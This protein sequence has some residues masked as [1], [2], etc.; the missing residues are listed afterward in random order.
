MSHRVLSARPAAWLVLLLLAAPVRSAPA[1]L[2]LQPGSVVA[3][4]GGADVAGLLESGHLETLLTL[5][6]AGDP[7]RFRNFGWEGDTVFQQPRDYGFAPLTDHLRRAAVTAAFLQFGRSEA[8]GDRLDLEEF[9]RAYR[10]LLD[11]FQALGMKIALVTP[12]PFEDGPAP[13]PP[14]SS[15][16]AQLARIAT[17]IRALAE[18]R[19]LACVDLFARLREREAGV[20]LTNDGLQLTASGHALIAVAFAR[21]LGVPLS[22]AATRW[23]Q[24]GEWLAPELEGL[25]GAI[26]EKNRLWFHF[27]RP[28]NWAFLGGDRIEQ[29]SSRDHRNPSVRWFPSEME[30]FR[31]LI[32]SRECEIATRAASV[33]GGAQ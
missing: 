24:Q 26:N 15:R 23:N 5:A 28:Q 20:R 13:L 33:R 16:N 17:A 30:K 18:E 8:L 4:V 21:E 29:P 1:D 10:G 27:W 19:N 22:P 31:P 11:S 7:P 14:L 12:P 32:E 6:R 25:R 9:A 2:L 3:L